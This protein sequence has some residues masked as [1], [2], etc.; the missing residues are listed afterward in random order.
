MAGLMMKPN[1]TPGP[2][3]GD[4]IRGFGFGHD[5]TVDT[6]ENFASAHHFRLDK[7]ARKDVEEFIMVFPTDLAPIVGQQVT[8]TNTNSANT[9]PRID[10]LE[11]RASASFE[12]WALG[13]A[14][15]ECDLIAK[16]VVNEGG[17]DVARGW[18]Y[19]GSSYVSDHGTPTPVVI[20]SST[21]RGMATAP[22]HAITFTCAPPGSGERMGVDRDGDG[23][24]DGNE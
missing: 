20:G 1:F 16:G 7:Q 11:A 21:L 14:V 6:I 18:W 12:S 10:E 4:Q 19:N 17:D 2:H 9:G 23:T 13:G 8:L 22:D 5:G 24:Y 15:T 3:M